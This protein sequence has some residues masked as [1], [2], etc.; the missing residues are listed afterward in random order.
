M[1]KDTDEGYRYLYII[2]LWAGGY[3]LVFQQIVQSFMIWVD[4]EKKMSN[5]TSMLSEDS[6]RL[7]SDSY[8]LAQQST[9]F[10]HKGRGLSSAG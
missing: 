1:G 6:G 7:I 8:P 5:L 10:H 2:C 3:D 4:G 9:L